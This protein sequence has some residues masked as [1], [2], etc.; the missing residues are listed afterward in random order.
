MKN[1]L[2]LFSLVSLLATCGTEIPEESTITIDDQTTQKE[3]EKAE[4]KQGQTHQTLND[5]TASTKVTVE[6]TVEVATGDQDNDFD[7]PYLFFTTRETSWVD[8]LDSAP[9][10]YALITRLEA[11][12]LIESGDIFEYISEDD[13]FWTESE[14]KEGSA[15][16]VDATHGHSWS[17]LKISKFPALYIRVVE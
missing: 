15:W 16:L 8:A 14:S 9:T 5:K 11:L 4:A 7:A 10:G 1:L 2:R 17:M 3:E 13:F 6:V 12:A